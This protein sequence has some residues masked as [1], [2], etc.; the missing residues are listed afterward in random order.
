[1][2]LGS[3][4]HSLTFGGGTSYQF[5]RFLNGQAQATRYDQYYFGHDYTGTFVSGGL[6]YGKRLLDMFTFSGGIVDSANGQGDNAVGFVGNVNFSRRLKGWSTSAVFS[7]AQNVQSALVTYTTSSYSYSA[8]LRHRLPGG[9]QWTAAFNGS[10]SGLTNYQ[11]TNNHSESYSSS[12]GSR[13]VNFT[14]NYGQATGTSLLG[15]GGLQGVP[16]TPGVNDFILFTGSNYGGGF[17]VQP[18]RRMVLSGAYSRAISNTL[19]QTDSHNNTQI[20][21]AQLQYHLRRIGLQAGYTRFNQGISA[22][23]APQS[24]TTYFAGFTRW[25][26]FF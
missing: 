6:N 16:P 17:S 26:D 23:G 13:K 3:G 8:N 7:Y 24:T 15:A 18:F 10:H 22:V 1:M 5:T 2:D 20:Y 4:S 14:A 25:F 19:G 11:G 9:W 12:L 21:N